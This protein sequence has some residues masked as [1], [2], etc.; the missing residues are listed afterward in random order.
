MTFKQ[1]GKSSSYYAL[2]KSG[3]DNHYHL[4]TEDPTE[5]DMS[6]EHKFLSYEEIKKHY[7]YITEEELT[8]GTTTA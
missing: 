8:S 3:W 6:H 7:K 4:I 1:I 2:V 5:G